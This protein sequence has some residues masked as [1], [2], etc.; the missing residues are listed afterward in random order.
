MSENQDIRVKKML[1]GLVGIDAA[2]HI[3]GMHREM[4]Q[5]IIEGRR[6][7]EVD[8]VREEGP[9]KVGVMAFEE[10]D[11]RWRVETLDDVYPGQMGPIVVKDATERLAMAEF[12]MILLCRMVQDR[13]CREDEARKRA[14]KADISVLGRVPFIRIVSK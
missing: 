9:M 4:R 13:F 7:R 2:P 8:G 11:G 3:R 12:R 5:T 6:R 10:S 14:L 1:E